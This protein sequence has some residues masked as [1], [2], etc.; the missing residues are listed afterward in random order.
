MEIKTMR[1]HLNNH[2]RAVL[3]TLAAILLSGCGW[4]GAYIRHNLEVADR[5]DTYQ[6]Y[7][8]YDYYTSGTLEDP[9]AV[10]A[11]KP[12]YAVTSTDWQPVAMTTEKL[13]EWVLAL[14]KDPFVEF[15]TF[16]NGAQIIDDQGDVAGFYYS[17]WDF[18]IIRFSESGELL[19]NK[20]L[21]VYRY[22]NTVRGRIADEDGMLDNW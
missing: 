19:I 17:V 21:P 5:F 20:P 16:S 6:V 18:P 3:S 22:H 1:N 13:Q 14:K 15:N 11:L 9:R 4:Y 7:S 12:G 2:R 8:G 10:L